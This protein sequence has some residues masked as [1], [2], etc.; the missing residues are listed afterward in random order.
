MTKHTAMAALALL[1]ILALPGPGFAVEAE[2]AHTAG[3]LPKPAASP[4]SA[5]TS[6]HSN[7]PRSFATNHD[8]LCTPY[9]LNCHSKAEMDRHHTV[10]T[11]LPSTADA[12]HD[13]QLTAD[14]KIACITCHDMAQPRYDKVRWKASSL[15]ERLFHQENRYKTYFLAMKND[16][17]QLCLTC[18]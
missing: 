12:E 4:S 16:Q 6:C 7:T 2:D 10:G 5:C 8:S 3:C 13:M 14:K 1:S 18:H 9:C 11:P 15:F 17:G